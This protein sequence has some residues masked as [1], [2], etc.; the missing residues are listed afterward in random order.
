MAHVLE[1]VFPG[2]LTHEDLAWLKKADDAG[3]DYQRLSSADIIRWVAD[4]ELH[5]F[6]LRHGQGVVLVE[7]RL[8]A[9]G[10]KRLGIVRAAGAGMGWTFAKIAELLQHTAKEWGCE[11][12][13]TM[14]YSPRLAKAMQ[15]IGAKPEAVNMVL[16]V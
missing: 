12:V 8:A 16:E 15:K 10:K 1:Y 14:V 3:S 5:L 2:D 9:S 11:A 4:G 13:E 6:R 7:V